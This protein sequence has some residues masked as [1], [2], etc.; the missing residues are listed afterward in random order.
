MTLASSSGAPVSYPSTRVRCRE[1]ALSGV[2]L[3][4]PRAG[5]ARPTGTPTGGA[6]ACCWPGC[7]TGDICVGG[8]RESGDF[9][10]D[11]ARAWRMD[12]AEGLKWPHLGQTYSEMA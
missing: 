2:G 7:C 8:T 6:N 3:E 1:E 11:A 4:L 9:D 12:R 5:P 10:F